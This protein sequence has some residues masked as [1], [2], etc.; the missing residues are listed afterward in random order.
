[1]VGQSKESSD[2]DKPILGDYFVIE[3]LDKAYSR[4]LL[5][6]GGEGTLKTYGHLSKQAD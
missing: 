6:F 4:F 2:L 5:C 3:L 1:M